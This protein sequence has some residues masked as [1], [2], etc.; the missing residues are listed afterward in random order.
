MAKKQK[1]APVKKPAKPAP[2][3]KPAPGAKKA[4]L[5]KRA[6]AGKAR[7]PEAKPQKSDD[8]KR[9]IL[10]RKTTKPI[11]FSLDEDQGG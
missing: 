3:R 2:S 1:P 9:R 6:P 11:A 4:P 7:A 10:E 5:A 8:L